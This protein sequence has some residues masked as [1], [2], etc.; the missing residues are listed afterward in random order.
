VL[1]NSTKTELITY[2][3]LDQWWHMFKLRTSPAADPSMREVM[4]SLLDDFR[5][6]WPMHFDQ[7]EAAA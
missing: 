2:A 6:F 7:I 1:P 4:I 5:G 3:N